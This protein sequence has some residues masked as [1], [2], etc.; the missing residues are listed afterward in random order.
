MAGP[1]IELELGVRSPDD[2]GQDRAAGIVARLRE[3]GTSVR[4]DGPPWHTDV[5]TDDLAVA[6]RSLG[7]DLGSID[8]GWEEVL[9]IGPARG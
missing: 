7:A 9:T 1:W 3:Q 4:G 2:A 8:E 5:E 6:L